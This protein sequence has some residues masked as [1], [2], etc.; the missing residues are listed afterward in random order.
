MPFKDQVAKNEYERKRRKQKRI[1][2]ARIKFTVPREGAREE[3]V[4][5]LVASAISTVKY[6][7]YHN[8]N[9]IP[10]VRPKDAKRMRY[11]TNAK[12]NIRCRLQSRLAE[13]FRGKGSLKGSTTPSLVGCS[14]DELKQHLLGSDGTLEGKHIDHIFPISKYDLE[15]QASMA[16]HWSN[17]RVCNAFLNQSKS[18]ALPSLELAMTVRRD[19]WP[20]GISE[21]DLQ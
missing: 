12:F 20:S 6:V 14:L 8:L 13:I 9:G 5:K 21:D 17:L 11:Q 16:M 1:E 10:N 19:C 15:T 7:A 18:D 4:R 3:L 2:A